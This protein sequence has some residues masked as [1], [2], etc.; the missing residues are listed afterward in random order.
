MKEDKEKPEVKITA[1][2]ELL[3]Q[4]TVESRLKDLPSSTS[5]SIEKLIDDKVAKAER[6]YYKI[7]GWTVPSLLVAG[8]MFFRATSQNAS[9]KVSEAIRNSAVG[10]KLKDVQKD[11]DQIQNIRNQVA[12][13]GAEALTNATKITAKLRELESQDNIVRV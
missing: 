11:Y 9:E 6:V 4:K 10:E 13:I 2:M 3:I 8:L 1:E 12:S 5:Q 7:L